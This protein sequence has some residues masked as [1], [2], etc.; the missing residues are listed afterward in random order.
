M[1]YILCLITILFFSTLEVTGKLIGANISPAS[2]TAYRFII[3]AVVLAPMAIGELKKRHIKLTSKEFIGIGIPGI[4]NVAVSMFLL[5][6]SIYYG[7]AFLSAIIISINPIFTSISAHIILKEKMPPRVIIAQ[8]FSILALIGIVLQEKELLAGSRDLALGI[9]FALMAAL[10]FA[11][12]TVLSKRQVKLHGSY[13]F[14][15]LSFF[16]GAVVLFLGTVIS[17]NTISF[18]PTIRNIGFLLYLGIF[19][20]GFAYF[21]FFTALKKLPTGVGA[22]FFFLKPV[23][24]GILAYIFL[25]EKVTHIQ[26]MLYILIGFAQLFIIFGNKKVIHGS[27]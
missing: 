11:L 1:A 25:S 10:T 4:L 13:V 15:S 2:I 20:T 19:V 6:L 24:A 12:Y 23:I 3:G 8:V 26:V 18:A 9:G 17:G 22:S 21:L 7:K 27:S 5:Q 16:I 14:N